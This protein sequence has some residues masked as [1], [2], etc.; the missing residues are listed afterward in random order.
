[1]P[2]KPLQK[3]LE[4]YHALR[5]TLAGSEGKWVSISEEKLIGIFDSYALAL[6]AAYAACG[7]KPFLVKKVE[8]IDSVLLVTRMVAP[9]PS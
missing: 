1:M 6:Q 9:C 5:P 8:T 2:E 4:T 3:E 7:L